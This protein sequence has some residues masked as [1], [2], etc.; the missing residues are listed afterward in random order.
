M[1][2]FASAGREWLGA[3]TGKLAALAG[4]ERMFTE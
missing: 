1:R 2:E 4:K 3:V